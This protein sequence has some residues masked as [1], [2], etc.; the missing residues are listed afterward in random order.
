MLR[1]AAKFGL[2]A[3]IVAL[4]TI[5]SHSAECGKHDTVVAFLITKYK[6][7]RIGIGVVANRGVMELFVSKPN[8]TWTVLLTNT[9][10]VAC[11]IAAGENFEKVKGLPLDPGA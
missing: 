3:A 4:S 2:V 9:K 7:Q 10:G 8:G 1:N 5:P 11:I 6:E